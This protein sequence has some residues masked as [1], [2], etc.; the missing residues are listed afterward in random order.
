[1][2]ERQV[3]IVER[4]Y[5]PAQ[6]QTSRRYTFLVLGLVAVIGLIVARSFYLQIVRGSQF[7]V[8]AEGNRVAIVPI[9]APR[10]ILFDRDGIPLVENIA[11]TDVV[12]D[13]TLLPPREEEKLL[14]DNLPRLT[15]ISPVS[16]QQAL[17]TTR[18]R[19]RITILARAIRH[20]DVVAIEEALDNLPGVRLIS[21]SVRQYRF[22]HAASHVLGYTGPVSAEEIASDT[23]LLL[24]DT[25][26]KAG[27]EKIYDQRLRGRH[28]ATLQ[29]VDATGH[30]R[31]AVGQQL[32]V[33]GDDLVL[34]LDSRLQEFV[35]SVLAEHDFKAQQDSLST[36][37]GSAVVILDPRSGAVRA[38]VSYPG[39][40][41]NT[42]SQPAQQ[43][44]AASYLQQERNPL[45]NRATHGAYP[46][47]STIKPFLAAGALEEGIITPETTVLSIGGIQVGP[48][49]FPDWKAGG[50]G[51]TNLN[52]AIA[53]SV[54]TFFY[55][56]TGGNETRQ[57]LGIKKATA[58]LA[59][60][61]LGS[62]TEIDLPSEAEG[63]LPSPEW[64]KKIKGESWYIGDT[65][66]LGIGQGDLL[67]TPLQVARAT[68][69]LAN[70]GALPM[71]Y[72]A[73]EHSPRRGRTLPIAAAHLK[74]VRD[75][76]RA[77][78]MGGS[79]RRLSNLP[80]AV[81]GKTGTAQIGESDDTHAWFT[82]FG[83]YEAPELVITVLLERG[84]AGERDAVPIAQEIW[85]WW[86]ENHNS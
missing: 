13:P 55:I 6:P 22:G 36:A 38:L 75:G 81:A 63:F 35:F 14:L 43:Q 56:I 73:A 68:A 40:D 12:L 42:F 47:G 8:Q 9:P 19:G 49:F 74:A 5:Q 7:R 11:S 53:E 71:P 37:T 65:Y 82:S 84:G 27:I 4:G 58:Y 16:V 29:E 52:K 60:F 17:E 70:G 50:H 61:G 67:V 3:T 72:L 64:K 44:H 28:G 21:S 20:D 80:I 79:A 18:T 76:M 31:R 32:P 69:A 1:M 10:G 41:P 77:A 83:P 86:I 39:F 24:T 54:N 15:S 48:W 26:G 25:V 34:T 62:P 2:D 85:N 33:P 57:G 30:S 78:V 23:G 46:P 66:H 59:R 45:F 51:V